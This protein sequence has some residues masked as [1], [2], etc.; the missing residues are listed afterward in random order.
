M[1]TVCHVNYDHFFFRGTGLNRL[2]SPL[3]QYFEDEQKVK[4]TLWDMSQKDPEVR[5]LQNLHHYLKIGPYIEKR[6]AMGYS[7]SRDNV[8]RDTSK[9]L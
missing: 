6:N 4:D 5:V 3:Y 8:V 9:E 7:E 2:V 1:F